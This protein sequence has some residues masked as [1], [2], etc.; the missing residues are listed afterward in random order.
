[1]INMLRNKE[2]KIYITLLLLVGIIGTLAVF[3][4][5]TIA[6]IV[7][8]LSL[9]LM[10]AVALLFTRWRY[11]QLDELSNYL[12][13]IASGAYTL[14]IRDNEEGELSILKSEIS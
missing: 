9:L 13:R 8:G 12:K 14:D 1:V 3:L 4:I 6:G 7:A 11:K 5:D 2:I 10:L